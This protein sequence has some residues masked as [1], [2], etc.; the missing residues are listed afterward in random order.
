MYRIVLAGLF[1]PLVFSLSAQETVSVNATFSNCAPDMTIYAFDGVDFEPFATVRSQ[2]GAFEF[3]VPADGHRFFYMGTSQR[4]LQ[5]IVLGAEEGVEV[6]GDCTDRSGNLLIRNSLINLQ[7]QELKKRFQ[8]LQ[9]QNQ[10][11]I[12]A[13]RRTINLP[14]D[15]A[16]K[17]DAVNQ[18]AAVDAARLA[19]L[20][21]L[22]EAN[23]FLY[24]IATLNT[25]LSYVNHGTDRYASEAPYFAHEYFR[26]VDWS[27]EGYHQLP[28]VF[29]A[30]KMYSGTLT[31]L[32]LSAAEFESMVDVTLD[33]IPAGSGAEKMALSGILTTL[34]Q[35]THGSFVHYV[36]RFAEHFGDTDPDAVANLQMEM[37]QM[38]AFLVGGEAPDFSQPNP[39]GESLSLSEL[40]GKVVL[41]DFWAS[42]CGPCRRENP[43]VVRLYEE[44]KDDGFEILGVSLDRTKDR[45]LQAIAQDGLE[46]LHVS[47]L[48]GWQNEVAQLYGVTSIPH[49]VLLDAEGRIIAR[50]LRG[51]SLEAKLAEIFPTN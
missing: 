15:N 48:K 17:R 13:F 49:T 32:N 10:N 4:N 41:V 30:F 23:Y 47:D 18:M 42:W 46:W 39:E 6:E 33:K 21:S 45:W 7:Y 34:K 25:Y 14:D 27:D 44:Y 2:T 11:A 29:E 38:S 16:E 9:Q 20:D 24:R 50:G 3:K 37:R 35:K 31:Q 26:F 51:P 19:L 12:Y 1:L 22:K 43:N 28:W 40:R 5:P 8:E 36:D